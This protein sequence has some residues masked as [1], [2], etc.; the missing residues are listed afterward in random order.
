MMRLFVA[1]VPPQ[2]VVADLDEFV[3]P[4]R[5]VPDG[6]RWISSHYWHL[7]LA[8]MGN[9]LARD[10]DE[11]EERL[12]EV[13]QRTRPF[14]MFLTG[15]GVFPDPTAARVLWAGVDS[16]GGASLG[17]LAQRC[18]TAAGRAGMRVDGATFHPH[19]TLARWRTPI[20]GTRWLKA[21]GQYRGP[22]WTVD[23]FVLIH[24]HMGHAGPPR[25]ETLAEFSL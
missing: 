4:R 9:A 3:E 6:P 25:Y 12:T 13:A 10:L 2:D 18:R 22:S 5:L 7:T 20:E 23:R 14:D 17:R 16:D 11:L 24:S 15:A 1:V 19:L 21:L 8:F